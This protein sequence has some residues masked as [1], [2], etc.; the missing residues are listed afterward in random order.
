M[1]AQ[2]LRFTNPGKLFKVEPRPDSMSRHHVPPRHPAKN[3]P[4]LLRKSVKDHRAYHQ[5]FRNAGSYEQCC[6]ILLREWWT[7]PAERT[8]K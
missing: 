5:L 8:N 4:F 7:P 6:E 3:T 2:A 1:S